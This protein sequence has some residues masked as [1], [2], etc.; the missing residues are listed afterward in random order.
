MDSTIVIKEER[1]TP[2]A[3]IGVKHAFKTCAEDIRH[4]NH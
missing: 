2:D 4:G 3:Y 1:L